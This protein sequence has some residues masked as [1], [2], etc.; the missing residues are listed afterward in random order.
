MRRKVVFV[1][2]AVAFG[3]SIVVLAHLVRFLDRERF[4]PVLVTLM[5][6]DVL[7][8]L[9]DPQVR[10]H[11]LDYRADYTRRDRFL[12]RFRRFGPLVNRLGAYLFTL[13]S[14]G[15]DIAYSVRLWR[16][17]RAERPDLVHINNNALHAAEVCAVAG[18]PFLWHFHGLPPGERLSAW[19]RWVLRRARRFVSISEYVSSLAGEYRR[20]GFQPIDVIPNPAPRMVDAPATELLELRRR[21][22]IRPDA[23]VIG[24]FGRLVRWKG[25]LEFLRAFGAVRHEFPNAVALIVGNASDLGQE[26][27][28]ELRACV[29]R[30]LCD[31]VVFTGYTPDVVPLYQMCDIVVHA[32][33][34]PE[35]FGLVIV[36][37]MSAG[38]AVVASQLGAG[39]ELVADGET[40]LVVDPRRPDLLANALRR[41]L[42]N[43]GLRARLARQGKDYARAKFDPG[44]YALSLGELYNRLLV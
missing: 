40:G 36:E 16:V 18:I 31:S 34:E 10:I 38:A 30:E 19:R 37:A 1:D 2:Q 27:E 26:Y 4:E 35:P 22:K 44:H 42:G 33:I 43:A 24:I 5:P 20:P 11:R 14:L 13:L 8:D 12:T 17:L 3:G 15:S 28:A 32:S 21:W 6:P 25:Q 29:S 7:R 23:L 9:F 39:P 41:L